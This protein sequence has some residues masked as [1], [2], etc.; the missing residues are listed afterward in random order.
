MGQ[1]KLDKEKIKKIIEDELNE[2]IDGYNVSIK[3]ID[4]DLKGAKVQ[5]T[6]G[7]HT[8]DDDYI[9]LCFY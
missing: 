1:A 2:M 6:F 9:G 3:D 8:V 4:V 7:L 5:V